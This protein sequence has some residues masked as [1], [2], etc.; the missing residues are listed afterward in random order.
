MSFVIAS[1]CVFNN[2]IDRDIDHLMER[3]KDRVLVKNQISG[4]VALI[5]AI[6]LGLIG[7]LILYF[8]TNLLTVIVAVIG[9]FFY[10][11]V[12]SLW[13]KR[14]SIYGTIVGGVAGAVP[15][16]AG[17]CAVTN[18]FDMGAVILFFILFLWQ[19]PHFYAISIYRVNDYKAAEIPI[20]PVIKNVYYTKVSML[21]YII[22]FTIAAIMP[23]VF[24]YTGLIYFI[25]ALCIGLIW[26]A[27]G[28]QGLFIKDD[29]SWARSMFVFSIINITVL[30][31]MM[32]VK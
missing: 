3:T 32:L 20:L 1:G 18:N 13:L 19:I 9:W 22:A 4:K 8:Q 27:L 11:A 25:V 16:V 28:I 7:L 29:M 31:V 21:S 24:G 5:Y 17:Y 12:Y 6:L 14:K 15:P 30:S 26:L 2:Y 10:V 23:S